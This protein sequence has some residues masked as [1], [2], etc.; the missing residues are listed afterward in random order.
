MKKPLLIYAALTGSKYSKESNQHAPQGVPTIPYSY[1]EALEDAK[2]CYRLGARLIHV[3]SRGNNGEH[4]MD[5]KWYSK[6]GQQIRKL[7]PDISLCF[8]T[9]RTGHV[10]KQIGKRLQALLNSG[11]PEMEAFINAEFERIAYLETDNI[12]SLPD[13]ITAFTATE[14]KMLDNTLETGHVNDVESPEKT[15]QFFETLI[16]ETNKRGIKQEIE[17]TT[18][19]SLDLIEKTEYST[20]WGQK[21]SIV[22]LPGFTKFFPFSTETLDNMI[23]RAKRWLDQIGG[24]LITLGR[25]LSHNDD[26]ISARQEYIKYS[27]HNPHIN[28]IRVGIEDSP[29]WG[30]QILSNPQLVLQTAQLIKEYGGDINLN[31]K[32]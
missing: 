19:N 27:L 22:F 6:F 23:L 29:F 17:I 32:L 1:E 8:A 21:P 31:P 5:T 16:S 13:Y 7:Y 30:N 18:L 25:V 3:H 9:S 4:L 24:G 11:M 2:E 28:A 26:S 10:A 14:V 20:H 12:T 15:R